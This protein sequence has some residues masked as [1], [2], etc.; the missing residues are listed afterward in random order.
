VF[1]LAQSFNSTRSIQWLPSAHD[2]SSPNSHVN[3]DV[4]PCPNPTFDLVIFSVSFYSLPD[5][6]TRFLTPQE[7]REPPSRRGGRRGPLGAGGRPPRPPAQGVSPLQAP[8]PVAEAPLLR[9][10]HPPLLSQH[11]PRNENRWPPTQQHSRGEVPILRNGQRAVRGGRYRF[12]Q[13]IVSGTK[14]TS[15][16]CNFFLSISP[17]FRALMGLQ[18]TRRLKAQGL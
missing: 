10:S 13:V 17:C 16:K 2:S 14:F 15:V 1:P 5:L 9:G 3:P 18:E 6:S 7:G 4:V 8:P 12:V 11:L